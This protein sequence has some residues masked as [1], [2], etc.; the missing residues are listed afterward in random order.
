MEGLDSW[1]A[2]ALAALERSSL[3]EAVRATPFVYPSLSSLHIL[4]VA[5][6]VG[7]ALAVDL[8][9]LGVARSVVPVTVVTRYL[10]PL[11]HLGFALAAVSGAALFAAGALTIAASAAAPWKLGLLVLAGI[12]VSLFHRGVYRT[13]GQ[14]D[15][16]ARPPARARWAALVSAVIWTGVIVAGR[17]LAFI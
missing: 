17:L 6:L 9:L 2:S 14:W 12:N 4:G 16:H 3:G 5:L 10:L 8:R 15:L 1:L 13:V 7:P 11:S